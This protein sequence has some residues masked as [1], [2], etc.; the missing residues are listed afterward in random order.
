MITVTFYKRVWYGHKAIYAVKVLP[1]E[2]GDVIL[3]IAR[4]AREKGIFQY[5]IGVS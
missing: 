5:K 3:T 2:L 4:V 1:Y